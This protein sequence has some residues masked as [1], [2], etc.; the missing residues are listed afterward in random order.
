VEERVDQRRVH[1]I[2]H[3]QRE[4][5]GGQRLRRRLVIFIECGADAIGG[6]Q[7]QPQCLQRVGVEWQGDPVPAE[8][9]EQRVDGVGLRGRPQVPFQQ[10][11]PISEEPAHEQ[12]LVLVPG[13]MLQ[14][15]QHAVRHALHAVQPHV[16]GG[17][18]KPRHGR[19]IRV[20][21]IPGVIRGAELRCDAPELVGERGKEILASHLSLLCGPVAG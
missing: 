19:Y 6:L 9:R 15:G 11:S 13:H 20:I 17:F 7:F 18:R 12:P 14:V 5:T 2:G 16:P 8:M 4:I 3:L 21:R 1:V 10:A